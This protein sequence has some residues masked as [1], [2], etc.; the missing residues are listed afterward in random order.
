[1]VIGLILILQLIRLDV[2]HQWFPVTSPQVDGVDTMTSSKDI[3]AGNKMRV[4]LYQNDSELSKGSIRNIE[5]ALEYAK[6]PHERI[7]RKQI[8]NLTSSPYSVL[9]LAGEHS[10]QWPKEAITTFVKEGGRVMF[11]GRFVDDKWNDLLGIKE[12]KGFKNGLKGI[13]FEKELFP[14]Y[15]DLDSSSTL[16]THSIT[17]VELEEDVEVPLTVEEEPLIWFNDVGKGK[18][19]FWNSTVVTNKSVRGLLLHSMS[20]LPPS[21][22]STQASIK[23]MHLDDFP[24]PIPSSTTDKIN[25]E[26]G[27]S[28]KDFYTDVWWEDMK[29]LKSEYDFT[30]TGYLIGTYREDKELTGENLK[31]NVRYP[32]LY[33]GRSLLNGGGEIGLHGYNHQSMV[34]REEPIDPELGYVPWEDQKQMEDMIGETKNL[35]QYYFPE[36]ALRSYVPPS[37]VL[38]RTGIAALAESLPELRTISSLYTGGDKG[39]YK[40]EFE[41]DKRF[42]GLYHFPRITSGYVDKEEQFLMTDAIANMGIFTHFIHPD[43]VLDSHRSNGLK[44]EDLYEDLQG[45]GKHMTTHYPYLESLTQSNATEKMIQYQES[46]ISVSYEEDNI[47]IAGENI[48]SPTHLFIRVEEGKSIEEGSHSFGTVEEYSVGLYKITMQEPRADIPLKGGDQ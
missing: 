31:K 13:T 38:N 3:E 33:F 20:L 43:D 24:A 14:G 32:M 36:E 45:L 25:E 12:N 16:L 2:F 40:Q 42:E 37:N 8:E 41:M 47:I 11:A 39:S 15:V 35:F 27:L 10:E 34:T 44:W 29:E 5:Q 26:Y 1:M 4:H 18:I 48:L 21:F 22:V 28:I 9:V 17:S 23:V 19:M 30:Y 6:V 46:D 7:D